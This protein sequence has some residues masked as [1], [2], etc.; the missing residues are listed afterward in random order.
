MTRKTNARDKLAELEHLQNDLDVSLPGPARRQGRLHVLAQVLR[1]AIE[2]LRAMGFQV[3]AAPEVETDVYNYTLLNV[4]PYHPARDMQDTF[5]I[6]ATASGLAEAEEWLLRTHTSASQV[7][8][9]RRFAPPMRVAVPGFCYRPDKPDPSHDWMFFQMEGFAIGRGITI[10]D[11]RGT[12]DTLVRR[13]LGP[14]S[15]VRF[16]AHYFPFTEPSVE[17]DLLCTL[18]RGEGCRLCG[19]SGWLEIIP[20]GMIHPQVLRNG[21]IDPDVY[22]GFAF[23]AGLDRIAALRYGIKDIRH[24]YQNDLNLLEQF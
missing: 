15:R 13:L 21:G 1:D 22:S 23:G 8:I 4:P 2:A 18:C 3:M 16:R 7:R 11:L 12:I 5:Y 10:G 9:M 19:A 14:A 24:L 6:D 20:G 17:V